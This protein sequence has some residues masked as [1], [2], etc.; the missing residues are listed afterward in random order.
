M[1]RTLKFF[2]LIAL[3]LAFTACEK[4]SYSVPAEESVQSMD[5]TLTGDAHKLKDRYVANL[6]MLNMSGVSG[7][8][9]ITLEDG[10]MTVHIEASG[11]VP[12]VAHVQHIHG[13]P[14]SPRAATCP[15]PSADTDGD[16][17]I[18]VPE[19]APF[20]GAILLPLTEFPV[21]DANGNIDYTK[22]FEYTS[23]LGQLQKREIVLHG[24]N[25][26]GEYLPSMPVA[27]GKIQV[28][29]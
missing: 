11:M 18:S 9:T 7:M 16:G 10:M 23:D 13:F 28:K 27:C 12:N 29:K 2:P 21:A 20:Y 25:F 3:L 5:A 14:D 26:M 1:N 24:G 22:T 15:P 19:G 4:E 17:M 8:A 6:D